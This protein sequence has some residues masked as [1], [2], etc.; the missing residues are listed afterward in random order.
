MHVLKFS[1]AYE[2]WRKKK[3]SYLD[4]SAFLVLVKWA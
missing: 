4:E 1:F 3:Q 2:V